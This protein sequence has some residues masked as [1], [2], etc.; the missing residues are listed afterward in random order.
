M[1]YFAKAPDRISTAAIEDGIEITAEQ[2]KAALA[3]LLD[4]EDTRV[5]TI[6]E[7]VFSLAEPPPPPEPEPPP[8]P[9][10]EQLQAYA[11]EKRRAVVFAGTTIDVGEGR[12]IPAWTDPEST[13]AITALVVA[14]QLNPA[15]STEWKGS[16][17]TFYEIDAAEMLALALGMMAHVQAAFQCEAVVLAAIAAEGITSKAQ[18]DA[19]A[20]PGNT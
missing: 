16:D 13:G 18:V 3:V 9:T 6:T 1:A 14:S 17:G 19:A 10:Q 20:W 4:E 5:I 7:G 12:E 11:A 8:P 15:L 2:Y